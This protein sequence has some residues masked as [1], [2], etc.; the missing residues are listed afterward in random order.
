LKEI[1][2]KVAEAGIAHQEKINKANANNNLKMENYLR[3][4]R[5]WGQRKFLPR[6]EEIRQRVDK[7]FTKR[8]NLKKKHGE[9]ILPWIEKSLNR[10]GTFITCLKGD[11]FNDCTGYVNLMGTRDKKAYYKAY[12]GFF[13]EFENMVAVYSEAIQNAFLEK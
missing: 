8:Q 13:S 9:V 6:L 4:Q 12:Y 7:L 10:I 3:R 11:K 5:D 1:F 2:L